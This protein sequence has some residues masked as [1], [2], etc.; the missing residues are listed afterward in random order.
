MKR[1]AF[2][3]ALAAAATLATGCATR[4]PNSCAAAPAAPVVVGERV[5]V[6]RGGETVAVPAPT[7]PARVWYLV[8]NIGLAEWLGLEVPF[9]SFVTN[10]AQRAAAAPRRTLFR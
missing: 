7:P 2:L 8:D 1:P 6:L 3:P 4:Q 9:T 10:D 5:R